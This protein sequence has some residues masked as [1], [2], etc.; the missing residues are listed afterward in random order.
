M[1]SLSS[2]LPQ[3]FPHISGY[4]LTEEIYEGSR[5]VVYRAVSATH[6]PVVI[7]VMGQSHPSFEEL[8]HFRNQYAITTNL[9]IPGIVRLISLDPWQN[10][11]A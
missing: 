8:V 9:P 2:T 11:Y 4:T 10:G 5:T 1:S 3:S 6:Q 7:K